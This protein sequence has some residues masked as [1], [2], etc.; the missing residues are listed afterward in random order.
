MDSGLEGR[1]LPSREPRAISSGDVH[2]RSTVGRRR[3]LEHDCLGP[4]PLLAL[5]AEAERRLL[6]HLQGSLHVTV[7]AAPCL[8]RFS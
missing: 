7:K 5:G 6:S 4:G 8:S 1:L 2:V 3:G